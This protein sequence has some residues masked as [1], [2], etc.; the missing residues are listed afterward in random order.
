M[1]GSRRLR[2]STAVNN[3][4]NAALMSAAR[5]GKAGLLGTKE[6]AAGAAPGKA[7]VAGSPAL[8]ALT[9]QAKAFGG[10]PLKAPTGLREVLH[11]PAAG[12]RTLKPAA[13][14]PKTIKRRN[15]LFSPAPRQSAS[16]LVTQEPALLLEPE[17]AP[18]KPAEPGFDAVGEFGFD[19]DIGL[20]PPT[21][22][23]MAGMR[24]A[25]LRAPDLSLEELAEVAAEPACLPKHHHTPAFDILDVP[26]LV[27]MPAPL[28]AS[29]LRPTR[30]PRLKRARQQ[31]EPRN[32]KRAAF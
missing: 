13:Q 32:T 11:T 2:G 7:A 21:Q 30:I 14:A 19:L 18:P 5:A 16:V 9:P 1:F 4:E 12:A 22:L 10:K 25:V 15:G 26:L 27:C 24:Q 20:V 31:V 17:Y 29:A 23:A 3:K 6:G 28:L 8:N